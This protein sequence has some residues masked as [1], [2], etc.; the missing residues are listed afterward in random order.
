MRI[1]RNGRR[2]CRIEWPQRR[3]DAG[4][5]IVA[6]KKLLDRP[7]M[8]R[9]GV[10]RRSGYVGRRF[11]GI[12][13]HHGSGRPEASARLKERSLGRGHAPWCSVG[14]HGGCDQTDQDHHRCENRH[15]DGLTSATKPDL[16][17][18]GDEQRGRRDR[19]NK[20]QRDSQA[21]EN[22]GGKHV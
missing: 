19:R 11:K 9:D 18:S 4:A 2:L 17:V 5:W 8:T 1:N 20:E 14:H 6:G 3:A 21:L 16:D 13:R 15:H 10:G 12:P 7:M 22:G